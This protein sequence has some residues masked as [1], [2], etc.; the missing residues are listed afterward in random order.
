[1][2]LDWENYTEHLNALCESYSVFLAF[3]LLLSP[4]A[5]T[6]KRVKGYNTDINDSGKG[7]IN[8]NQCSC[9]QIRCF[10]SHDLPLLLVFAICRSLVR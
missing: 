10:S 4:V 9:F 6:F 2:V 3:N 1:M 7:D 5:I 8:E